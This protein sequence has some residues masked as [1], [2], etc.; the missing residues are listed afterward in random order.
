MLQEG[1]QDVLID[2]VQP[3]NILPNSN[4][5]VAPEYSTILPLST[6]N[7]VVK[8]AKPCHF[9][10][11]R[12]GV[13]AHPSLLGETTCCCAT[14]S[15]MCAIHLGVFQECT[16]ASRSWIMSSCSPGPPT[17]IGGASTISSADIPLIIAQN[18]GM[19]GRRLRATRN[20][21]DW[22]TMPQEAQWGSLVMR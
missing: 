19:G 16:C 7:M 15:F 18:C 20:A 13:P 8:V 21:S 11:H 14:N 1:W 3:N 6:I 10:R 2:E 4:G 12:I 22:Q 9:L 5:S 17:H